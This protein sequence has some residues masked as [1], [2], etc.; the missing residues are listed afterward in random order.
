M[1]QSS[2]PDASISQASSPNPLL[3]VAALLAFILMTM[4]GSVA[5]MSELPV[6]ERQ[7]CW[8]DI[9]QGEAAECYLLTPAGKRRF[10]GVWT[11][12]IPVAILPSTQAES[13]D[14]LVFLDGGPG[15]SP[16]VS[17]EVWAA[18]VDMRPWWSQTR[19]LRRGRDLILIGQRGTRHSQP[20][21]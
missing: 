11:V 21:A 4:A 17:K 8:F 9:P 1:T 16:F 6:L 5:R 2:S 12:R 15:E 3:T 7:T 10:S 18:E 20:L 14:P 19:H 13:G